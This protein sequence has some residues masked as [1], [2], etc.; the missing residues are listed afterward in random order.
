[1]GKSRGHAGWRTAENWPERA[2]QLRDDGWLLL[3]LCGLD[4][5]GLGGT[6]R[7]EVVYQ[8]LH[9]ELKERQSIHVVASGEPPTVPS[10]TSL[11]PAANFYEREAYDMFGIEFEGHPNLTRILMPDEWE[12][13]PLRRDYGVGKVTIE[14]APQPFLQIDA[15]GQ[16][17][18]SIEAHEEVDRLGQPADPKRDLGNAPGA[19]DKTD[20]A[21]TQRT[22]GQQQ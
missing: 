14:F 15:P 10:V 17:P 12:G 13:Y 16:A 11:W 19:G 1:M 8:F 22:D 18:D 3:D 4:R 2:G 5:L 6:E 21:S 9:P 7:F 20:A